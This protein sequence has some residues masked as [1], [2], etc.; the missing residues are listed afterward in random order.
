M[1]KETAGNGYLEETEAVVKAYKDFGD[2]E[3][4]G[5]EKTVYVR[6]AGWKPNSVTLDVCEDS[7]A[8]KALDK[9]GKSIGPGEFRV[10]TIRVRLLK[11]DWKLWD[12]DGKKVDSCK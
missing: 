8:V 4:G 2:H 12:G 5:Q 11:G 3:E 1:M 6:Y 10:V 9:N 7:R